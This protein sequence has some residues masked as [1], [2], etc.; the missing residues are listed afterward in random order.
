M[1]EL[2]GS[3]RDGIT[4][5]FINLGANEKQAEVMAS[6][7][8]KRARQISEDREISVLEATENLLKQVIQARQGDASCADTDLKT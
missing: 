5:L 1:S 3:E 7:L 8:I 2:S 4:R 6:Q